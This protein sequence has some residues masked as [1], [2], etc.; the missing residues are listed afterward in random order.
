VTAPTTSGAVPATLGNAHAVPDGAAGLLLDG[1]A[2]GPPAARLLAHSLQQ[3][4]A[5]T[6]LGLALVVANALC[7]AG[8]PWLTVSLGSVQMLPENG[9]SPGASAV[10]AQAT[11]GPALVFRLAG[12]LAL[13][14]AA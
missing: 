2:F 5:A 14:A 1:L 9:L 11:L 7:L 8:W 12:R 6:F 3:T 13:D 4:R 10:V